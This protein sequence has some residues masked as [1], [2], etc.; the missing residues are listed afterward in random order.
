MHER[1]ANLRKE[2]VHQL[3]HK[4]V[5][6]WDV[7]CVED[8]NLKSL[9]K[10]KQAKSWLDASFGEL[11]RQIESKFRWNGKP[12]APVD[13]FFASSKLCTECGYKNNDLRLSDRQWKCRSCDTQQ[14]RDF[15]A[16][17]NVKSEGLRMLAAGCA[18]S[19]NSHGPDSQQSGQKRERCKP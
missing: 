18:E 17:V 15:N 1:V 12:F 9:A 19:R 6:W 14:V 11:F 16:A 7:V 4:P 10:T 2:F 5:Q 13:G 8:L 3:S